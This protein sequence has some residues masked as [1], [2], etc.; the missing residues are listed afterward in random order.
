MAK[1]RS[2]GKQLPYPSHSVFYTG[3]KLIS[4]YSDTK[5][6]HRRRWGLL[7]ERKTN[8]ETNSPPPPASPRPVLRRQRH[9]LHLSMCAFLIKTRQRYPLLNFNPNVQEFHVDVLLTEFN[10]YD[11]CCYTN[12]ATD[13]CFETL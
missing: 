5:I 2:F 8:T 10:C 12:R 4:Y 3:G 11:A 1:H 6:S 7:Y 13:I 9:L